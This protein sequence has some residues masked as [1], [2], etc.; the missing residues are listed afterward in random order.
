M[1]TCRQAQ[2]LRFRLCYRR[3]YYRRQLNTSHYWLS[4][5]SYGASGQPHFW[6]L[7][8]RLPQGDFS[9][10][11]DIFSCWCYQSATYF[12]AHDCNFASTT[13]Y[14]S[15]QMRLFS[16]IYCF[17]AVGRWVFPFYWVLYFRVIEA[18]QPLPP[19]YIAKVS[20]LMLLHHSFRWWDAGHH[21]HFAS[22]YSPHVTAYA[23]AMIISFLFVTFRYFH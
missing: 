4:R 19:A 12:K 10:C 5:I 9:R 6:R 18:I 13:N 14:V 21:G 7:I 15:L 1:F 16:Y 22:R 20:S 2:P 23:H 11:I 3:R 17:L 8:F